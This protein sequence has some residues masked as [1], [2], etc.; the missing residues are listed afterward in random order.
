[1]DVCATAALVA[2]AAAAR[3]R[4]PRPVADGPSVPLPGWSAF[5]SEAA[6]MDH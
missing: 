2:A 5:G 3:L 6:G 4:A 1:M